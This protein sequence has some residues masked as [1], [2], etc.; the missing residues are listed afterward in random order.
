MDAAGRG[1]RRGLRRPLGRAQSCRN[2]QRRLGRAQLA[3]LER[4]ILLARRGG[5]IVGGSA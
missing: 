5:R 4:E 2:I 3:V 1:R